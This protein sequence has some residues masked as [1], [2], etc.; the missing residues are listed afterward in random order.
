M[1][2]WC[3]EY[4][5]VHMVKWWNTLA[6][7]SSIS[8][9]FSAP[10]DSISCFIFHIVSGWC[11]VDGLIVPQ[12]VPMPFNAAYSRCFWL[13]HFI[14]T[15]LPPP[16][17]P[18]GFVPFWNL[19]I[20]D[21][22]RCSYTGDILYYLCATVTYTTFTSSIWSPHDCFAKGLLLD[23]CRSVSRSTQQIRS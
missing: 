13:I 17:T 23:P 18:G 3:R 2:K 4:T 8:S 15:F 21:T 6:E 16:P 9:I 7:I 1:V 14:F 19:L 22:P 20:I 10:L 5:Q 11:H 12:A